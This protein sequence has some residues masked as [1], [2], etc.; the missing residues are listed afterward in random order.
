MRGFIKS[1]FLCIITISFTLITAKDSLCK[2][3]YLTTQAKDKYGSKC[4]KLKN[5]LVVLKPV[6]AREVPSH[7]RVGIGGKERGCGQDKGGFGRRP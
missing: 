4:F 2:G 3:K 6:G 7:S 5:V 1:L